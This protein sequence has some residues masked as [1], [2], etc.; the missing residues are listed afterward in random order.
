MKFTILLITIILISG[1]VFAQDVVYARDSGFVETVSF[2]K[3]FGAS[4]LLPGFGNYL[5][6]NKKAYFI[7]GAM[8][9]SGIATSLYLHNQAVKNY[10]NYL[11]DKD[12]NSRKK[13]ADKWERQLQYSRWIAIGAAACW[14]ID[15]TII[16]NKHRKQN[17]MSRSNS[18]SSIHISPVVLPNISN[19]I[20]LT[21]NF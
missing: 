13:L 18:F 6:T 20:A 4:T 10:D 1:S 21:I 16:W 12:I 7:F 15:Y 8:A 11:I 2:S 14:L 3:A 19:G 9:Y 17:V 5:I